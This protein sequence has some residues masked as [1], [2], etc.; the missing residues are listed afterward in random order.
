MMHRAPCNA[1]AGG[2]LTLQLARAGCVNEKRDSP[3]SG[4]W[5]P[6]PQQ[7][8]KADTRSIAAYYFG[9]SPTQKSG[10]L[11]V[12][13]GTFIILVDNWKRDNKDELMDRNTR[14]MVITSLGIAV[15]F[16]LLRSTPQAI[17]ETAAMYYKPF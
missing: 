6:Q 9:L 11:F 10:Y 14:V 3:M 12:A 13:I 4:Y 15:F 2:C 17:K 7:A 16:L 5:Y 1:R 8:A